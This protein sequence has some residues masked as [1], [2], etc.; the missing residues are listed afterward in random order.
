MELNFR[1]HGAIVALGSLL[2]AVAC[3]T[4]SQSQLAQ[5]AQA[6]GNRPSDETVVATIGESTITLGDVDQ[7][8]LETNMKV[9]QELYDARRQVLGGLVAELLLSEEAAARGIIQDELVA[10]EITAQVPPVTEADV[11]AFYEQN[12]PRLGGQTLE[13]VGGQLRE[14]MVARNEQ[15]AR[16]AFI[17]GLRADANVAIALEAPRVP[18]VVTSNERIRGPEDA[19]ITIVEYSDFQ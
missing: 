7:K 10:Q 12:R 16:Q 2:L 17:D 19:E 15:S 9:F 3:G 8:L 18:V 5:Q 1:R 13:Q 11:Q 4:A 14:F 6:K